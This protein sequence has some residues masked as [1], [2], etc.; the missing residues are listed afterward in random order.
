MASLIPLRFDLLDVCS[1][2][3]RPWL[4]PFTADSGPQ[5]AEVTGCRGNVGD[6]F[7]LWI[8]ARLF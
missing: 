6:K 1:P 4:P 2:A 8:V 7:S 5:G 3:S